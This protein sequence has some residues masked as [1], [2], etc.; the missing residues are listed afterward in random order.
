MIPAAL[1]WAALV[2][3]AP[4]TPAPTP[5]AEPVRASQTQ[6]KRR[7]GRIML[8]LLPL[9]FAGFAGIHS[10][11]YGLRQDWIPCTTP[12]NPQ[13]A[14]AVETVLCVGLPAK[15]ELV[16]SA[17]PLTLATIGTMNLTQV[18]LEQGRP[19]WRRPSAIAA[20]ATG[21]VLIAG[22]F[23]AVVVSVVAEPPLF[24]EGEGWGWPFWTHVLVSQAGAAVMAGGGALAGAGSAHLRAASPRGRAKISITPT[25]SRPGM[26]ISGRF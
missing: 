6:E 21:S 4:P 22:G 18:R 8:G 25:W 17:A 16:A 23:A 19:P 26:T 20:L 11:G 10:F 14:F 5:A 1:L 15:I 13:A 2:A 7:F 9:S 24:R 12:R 3:P